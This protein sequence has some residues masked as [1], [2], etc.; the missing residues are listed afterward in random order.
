MNSTDQPHFKHHIFFCLNQRE[1]GESCCANQGAE[2]AFNHIKSCV[3]K[4]G[5][6]GEHKTR[7]NRAGCLDRCK[8]GPLMVIYPEAIW[9]TFVDNEDLDEIIESHLINGKVVK[10]LQI[11]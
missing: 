10:R 2:A 4:L 9:Y 1:D 11:E 5:L 7:V 8:Q 6:N 3:K